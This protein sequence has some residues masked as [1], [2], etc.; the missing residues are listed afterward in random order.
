MANEERGLGYQQHGMDDFMWEL[1]VREYG[2]MSICESTEDEGVDT[3][4]CLS[5]SGKIGLCAK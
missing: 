1:E 4:M 3:R 5:V 2:A